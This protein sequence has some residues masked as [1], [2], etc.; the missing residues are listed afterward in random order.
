MTGDEVTLLLGAPSARTDDAASM[1]AAAAAVLARGG[2]N[3]REMWAYPGGWSLYF[4]G[5]RLV[6]I[7]VA[8]KPPLYADESS[9]AMRSFADGAVSATLVGCADRRGARR[10]GAPR[11]W[12]SSRS[13]PSP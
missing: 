7:T 12:A 3:A 2:Q 1:A 6:D 9:R 8:G 11:D 4:D 5:D 13:S 10:C